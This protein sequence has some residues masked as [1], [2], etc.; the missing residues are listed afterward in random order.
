MTFDR[1]RFAFN[2]ILNFM[3]KSFKMAGF[4]MEKMGSLFFPLTVVDIHVFRF[5]ERVERFR[6]DS[7]SN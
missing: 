3:M 5:E 6:N 7:S 2:A 4:F 1:F